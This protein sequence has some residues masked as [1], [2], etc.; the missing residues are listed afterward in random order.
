MVLGS[1]KGERWNMAVSFCC[2]VYHSSL[3][4]RA[5]AIEP[6]I[7]PATHLPAMRLGSEQYC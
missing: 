6:G 4:V 7:L 3:L 2:S 1:T 5:D